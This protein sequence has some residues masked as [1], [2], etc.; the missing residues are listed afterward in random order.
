MKNDDHEAIEELIKH[1]IARE[2]NEKWIMRLI[3]VCVTCTCTIGGLLWE[4]TGWVYHHYKP[5]QAALAA[6]L[7]ADNG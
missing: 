4:A 7:K 5:L 3:C 2:V 6:F 1:D